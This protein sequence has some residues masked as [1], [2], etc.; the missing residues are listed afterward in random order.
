MRL[1]LTVPLLAVVA[2]CGEPAPPPE[3]RGGGAAG[4]VLG[5]TISDE[6][7]PLPQLTSQPPLSGPEAT[8]P[9]GGAVGEVGGTAAPATGA[10]TASPVPGA[11]RD[12]DEPEPESEPDLAAEPDAET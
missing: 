1:A 9:P 8:S 2:A 4:V 12:A 11:A 7:I 3:E 5:G 10:A 6:M